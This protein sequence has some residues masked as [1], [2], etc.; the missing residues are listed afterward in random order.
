MK[1]NEFGD[2]YFW[3]QR[4]AEEHRNKAINLIKE[5]DIS[6]FQII[7]WLIMGDQVKEEILRF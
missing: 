2:V 1:V 5:P 4:V 6:R 7:D 3:M